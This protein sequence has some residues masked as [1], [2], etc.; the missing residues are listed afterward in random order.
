MGA[1]HQEH[2]DAH[3]QV[4]ESYEAIYMKD[5][6]FATQRQYEDL[7]SFLFKLGVKSARPHWSFLSLLMTPLYGRGEYFV[8]QEYK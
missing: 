3:S 2:L 7:K 8:T 1:T 6:T 4:L 5:S